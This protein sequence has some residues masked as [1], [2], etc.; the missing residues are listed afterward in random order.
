MAASAEVLA[1]SV[2][3]IWE[4]R[5][6]AAG[7]LSD[8]GLDAGVGAELGVWRGTYSVH[9]LSSLPRLTTLHMIDCWDVVDV[10]Q[11]TN[12]QVTAHAAAIEAPH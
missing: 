6:C 7:L 3:L 9:L 10:Y 11:D 5:I 2:S 8:L 12:S 1:G 4:I